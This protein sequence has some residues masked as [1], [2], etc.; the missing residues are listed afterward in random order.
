MTIRMLRSLRTPFLLVASVASKGL[1]QQPAHADTS[2]PHVLVS[3]P[4]VQVH[5][6]M[7]LALVPDSLFKQ[8]DSTFRAAKQVAESLGFGFAV[9]L[10]AHLS[11]VDSHNAAV[12]YLPSDV[13]RGYLIIIPGQR[14]D[15]VRG[16]VAADSLRQRIKHY[17]QLIRPLK[18]R[19]C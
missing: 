7:V 1:A 2:A 12:Y 16:H 4:P 18:P 6:P 19:P 8:L 5:D 10:T 9:K 3:Q 17:R 13:S 15:I 11:V 14:P